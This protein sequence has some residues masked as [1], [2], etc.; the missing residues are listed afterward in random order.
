MDELTVLRE[1]F[2]SEDTPS[3]DSHDKARAALLQRIDTAGVNSAGARPVRAGRHRRRWALRV[4]LTAA[5][6]AAAVLGA[7]AV[8]NLGTVDDNGKGHPIVNALPFPQPASAAEVLE[9]AAWAADRKPWK[10]PR[11]DQFMY[12]ESHRLRGTPEREAREPNG[13][14]VAGK[15][16][17]VVEQEWKRID[18][19]ILA[20]MDKGNLVVMNKDEGAYFAQIPYTDLVKLTTPE[21]VLA[22]DAAPKQYGVVLD[23]LLG[24]YVLPPAVEAAMFRAIARGNGVRLN[25]VAVNIDGRPAIGLGRTIEGY[26]SQELLF[27]KATYRLIGERMVA[28]ADHTNVGNDGTSQTHKGD[29]FRQVTYTASTIVNKVGDTE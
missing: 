14:L 11:P 7:V 10:N 2:G 29:V 23:Q 5:V 19:R 6:A 3:A 9:N 17:V 21:K 18:G 22:W 15:T 26:L 16:R 4:G 27:D 20:R 1:A 8:E 28:I 12:N 13:P 25:P 24:Q